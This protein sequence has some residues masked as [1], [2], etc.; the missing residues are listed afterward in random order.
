MLTHISELFA[1]HINFYKIVLLLERAYIHRRCLA[2]RDPSYQELL[3]LSQRILRDFDCAVQ[4]I[5]K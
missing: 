4:N 3:V 2:S 5:A 1:T